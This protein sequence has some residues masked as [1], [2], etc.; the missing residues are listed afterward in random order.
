MTSLEKL[1][2]DLSLLRSVY[3]TGDFTPAEVVHEVYRRIEA[4]SQN[5]VWL[6]LRPEAEAI[7]L[8][9]AAA[10][11]LDLPLA[12][13]PFAIKDNL[14][15]A[16]IPT[17]A[18]C[19]DF[20]YIPEDSAAVVT[21]LEAAGAILIGKTNMDQFATGL[22][23]T[24]SPAGACFNAYHPNYISGG[25]SSGSAISVAYGFVSFSLGTDT[26]GSGRIPA[27]FN[28][29]VG[30]KPTRGTVSTRGVVPACRSLDCVSIFA[31]CVSDAACVL[32]VLVQEDPR[33]PWSRPVHAARRF[34]KPFRFGVPRQDQLEF[35][36]DVESEIGFQLAV[37]RMERLGGCRVELDFA[38]FQEAAKLLY[39]GAWVAERYAAVGSFIES[40]PKGVDPVVQ[41]IILNGKNLTAVSA[42][43]A[44][45]ELQ[46]LKKQC[47]SVWQDI[48]T[49]VVP[50]APTI[51]RLDE[52]AANPITLNS[53]LGIYTNF[54]NLLDLAAIA[55]PAGFRSDGIPFG[56][57][58]IAEAFSDWELCRLAKGF[59]GEDLSVKIQKPS[60]HETESEITLAVVGAHMTG[61]P[62]NHQLTDRRAVFL[63]SVET[64]PD[65]A[66]YALDTK[67]PKP[68]LV[69]VGHMMGVSIEAEIWSL[70]QEAF[71][72]FVAAVPSPMC[73]GTVQLKDGRAVKGF[74]CE[75]IA[76]RKAMPISAYGGWRGY[77]TS[78]A[79]NRT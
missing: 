75:E 72:S 8:A 41:S 45:Y 70:S 18:G 15:A 5:P 40:H 66:L 19:P 49:L 43:E 76:T 2:L 64:S 37:E 68:G 35:F 33:D 58:L 32:D 79:D 53:N 26:A 50:T 34:A 6:W 28:N 62:L 29:L 63:E 10:A 60:P 38:P 16:G 59:V 1:S 39:D 17:T 47:A 55:I 21:L 4:K 57:T 36:G 46:R 44:T 7:K 48:D 73:I 67:P 31:N 20:A 74:L 56:I 30:L 54:V 24:R 61:F 27:G 11:H 12:G 78:L 69:N 3:R 23:G 52:I 13:V 51:Y 71:G 77:L 14:D 9:E 42:F 25:S 22:V 65:Y